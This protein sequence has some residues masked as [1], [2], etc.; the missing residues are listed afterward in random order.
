MTTIK[1]KELSGDALDWVV[2]KIEAPQNLAST[3]DNFH[4]A[5]DWSQGG[6]IIEQEV[7]CLESEMGVHWWAR[8]KDAPESEVE[9]PTP[10]IAAMRCYVASKLGNEVEIPNEL[11]EKQANRRLKP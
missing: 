11:V 2:A 9:G 10:L 4:P 1:T 3:A 5:A 7:I 8:F 6:P